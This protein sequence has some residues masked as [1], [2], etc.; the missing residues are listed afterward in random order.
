MIPLTSEERKLHLSKKKCHICKNGFST[1]DDNKKYHK[2]GDHCHHTVQY[3]GAAH[4]ICNLRHKIPKKIP[5]VFYDGSTYDYYFI[6][7]GLKKEFKGQFK[8]L[9]DN[10]EKIITF[11]V[12]IN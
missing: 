11:S 8:C 10:T 6:I 7:N 3:R 5:V 9:G 12:P 1:D 4:D 2:V